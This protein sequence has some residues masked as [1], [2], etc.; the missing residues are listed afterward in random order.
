MNGSWANAWKMLSSERGFPKNIK[1]PELWSLLRDAERKDQIY[2]ESYQNNYRKDCERW[3]VGARPIAPSAPSASSFDEGAAVD[4]GAIGASSAPSCVGGM[5]DCARADDA[6]HEGVA[7]L[8]RRQARKNEGAKRN[9]T[10]R[11]SRSKMPNE[12]SQSLGE[13]AP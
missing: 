10:N 8:T 5:G 7:S 6:A 2:R 13:S 9:A 3:R 12:Q 4:E 1:K 11:K